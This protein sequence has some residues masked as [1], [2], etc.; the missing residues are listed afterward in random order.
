[1]FEQVS[2]LKIEITTLRESNEKYKKMNIEL[3]ESLGMSK[4]SVYQLREMKEFLEK[5]DREIMTLK[6]QLLLLGHE[7]ETSSRQC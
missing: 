7:H 3:E 5:K 1:M 6:D 2:K 4:D